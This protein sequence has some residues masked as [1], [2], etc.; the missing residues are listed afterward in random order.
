MKENTEYHYTVRL[1]GV[2]QEE[3]KGNPAY[4][5][6]SL[7]DTFLESYKEAGILEDFSINTYKAATHIKD[8]KKVTVLH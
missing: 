3:E 7:M 8:G 5:L 2:R 1:E 4:H 6:Q